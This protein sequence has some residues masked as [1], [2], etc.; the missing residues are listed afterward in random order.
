MLRQQSAGP[1]PRS[2]PQTG[3]EIPGIAGLPDGHKRPDYQWLCEAIS[4]SPTRQPA[5]QLLTDP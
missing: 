1:V 4:A 2:V 3:D 5:P